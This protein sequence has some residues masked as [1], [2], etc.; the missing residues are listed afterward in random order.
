M[1]ALPY[2]VDTFPSLFAFLLVSFFSSFTPSFPLHSLP[3][4]I[5]PSTAPTDS[6]QNVTAV[7]LSSTEI[8]VQWSGLPVSDRHGM[9]SFYEVLY[10]PHIQFDGQISIASLNTSDMTI[11]L[12]NLQEYVTYNISVRAYNRVGSG[13]Y[14]EDVIVTTLEDGKSNSLSDN[15]T[16]SIYHLLSTV[17]SAEPTN[18][19]AYSVSSSSIFMR[20]NEVPEIHQNGIILHYVVE[21]NQIILEFTTATNITINLLK[22]YTE[23]YLRVGSATSVGVGPFSDSLLTVTLQD[24][25]FHLLSQYTLLLRC[26]FSISSC[27]ST[28][29][30]HCD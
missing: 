12:V 26:A 23:Y 27:C 7:V 30:S 22:P 20:W 5:S 13:P 1:R 28:S 17:P 29:K 10:N 15:G 19:V 3:F 18:V 25:K 21:L 11:V 8:M 9:I 2:L 16:C 4:L 14:S 6:P 24:S